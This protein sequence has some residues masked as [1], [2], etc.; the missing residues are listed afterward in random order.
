MAADGCNH[1]SL[2]VDVG[3]ELEL[4]IVLAATGLNHPGEV[5][6]E[7][8]TEANVGSLA[9]GDGCHQ[10]WPWGPE[11]VPTTAGCNQGHVIDKKNNMV[12]HG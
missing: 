6:L 5:I 10:C 1:A 2:V 12:Y 7:D 3:M 11:L 9:K 8:P 4:I